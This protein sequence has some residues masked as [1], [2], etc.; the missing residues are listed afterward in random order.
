MRG[1]GEREGDRERGRGKGRER[2]GEGEREVQNL[3]HHAVVHISDLAIPSSIIPKPP[4]TTP[5]CKIPQGSGNDPDPM[6]ALTKLK[7]VAISL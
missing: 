3:I 2:E 7:K 6:L 4:A 1:E 5:A